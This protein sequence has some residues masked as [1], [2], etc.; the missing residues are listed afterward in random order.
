MIEETKDVE[1]FAMFQL[2][3]ASDVNLQIDALEAENAGD[4]IFQL[5]QSAPKS[6]PHEKSYNFTEEFANLNQQET[7]FFLRLIG[8]NYL[9]KKGIKAKTMFTCLMDRLTQI[10]ES[11]KKSSN[12]QI[13]QEKH[14]IFAEFYDKFYKGNSFGLQQIENSVALADEA[15]IALDL[16]GNEILEYDSTYPSG[17]IWSLNYLLRNQNHF[18]FKKSSVKAVA[19]LAQLFGN[20]CKTTYGID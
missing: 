6:T 19:A 5:L 4:K 18:F 16:Y 20:G 3:G 8:H 13:I 9:D 10:G 17:G 12:I 15:V 7:L 11:Q 14:R 1:S 2:A